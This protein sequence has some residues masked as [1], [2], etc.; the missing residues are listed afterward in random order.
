MI[1]DLS[2]GSIEHATFKE[3]MMPFLKKFISLNNIKYIHIG[4]KP[5]IIIK[6]I[7]EFQPEFLGTDPRYDHR[8]TDYV[9][10]VSTSS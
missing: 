5:E 1:I 6:E 8:A 3:S 10:G 2:P 7:N 9:A 4:E